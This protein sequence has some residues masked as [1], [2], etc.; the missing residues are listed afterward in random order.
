M[1]DLLPP[2]DVGDPKAFL[3]G[4]V[5]LFADYPAEV[6][7]Q[8]VFTIPQRSDRPTLKIARAVLDELYEPV[9]RRVERDAIERQ[10]KLLPRPRRSPEEQAR[11]DAQVAAWRARANVQ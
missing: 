6:F 4:M 2:Q 1:F 3:A 10:P 8:A 5:A 7:E 11:V 9:R